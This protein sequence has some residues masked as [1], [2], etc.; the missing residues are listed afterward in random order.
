MEVD[1]IKSNVKSEFVSYKLE[2][3]DF[4]KGVEGGENKYKIDA[5]KPLYLLRSG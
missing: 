4:S 3:T 2:N 5:N 1:N